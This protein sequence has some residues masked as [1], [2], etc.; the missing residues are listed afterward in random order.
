MTAKDAKEISFKAASMYLHDTL[1]KVDNVINAAANNGKLK[2]ILPYL[3]A[4]SLEVE[5]DLRR[6]GYSINRID[7]HGACQDSNGNVYNHNS[8]YMNQGSTNTA[9]VT[10]YFLDQVVPALAISQEDYYVLE[11]SWR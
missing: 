2:V 6:N 1:D 5:L 8:Q 7:L 9:K 4:K 10:P 11:V 3:G